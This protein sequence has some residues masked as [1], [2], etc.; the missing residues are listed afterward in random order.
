MTENEFPYQK[1]TNLA[2]CARSQ[3]TN[4]QDADSPEAPLMYLSNI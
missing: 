4:K 1:E 2:K 3:Q